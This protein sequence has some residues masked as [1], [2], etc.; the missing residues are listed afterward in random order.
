MTTAEQFRQG[1]PAAERWTYLNTAATSPTHEKVRAAMASFE[2]DRARRGEHGW[3]D[4]MDEVGGV[5]KVTSWFF[6][7][8]PEEVALMKNTSDG[9]ATVADGIQWKRGDEVV[10]T[11]QEFPSNILPWRQLKDRGVTLRIVESRNGLVREEDVERALSDRTR[12]LTFSS[13]FFT[14]G[15]ALD[16]KRL[17]AV[18]H[19]RGAEVLVDAIQGAGAVQT[20][21]RGWDVDYLACGGHKW[22]MAP[23]GVGT[24][25]VRRSLVESLKPTHV[26]WYGLADNEDYTPR[27]QD[28]A[29]TARR[30]EV[31]NLNLGGL[32]G[33][34][35]AL[36]TLT[37]VPDRQERVRDLSGRLVDTFRSAGLKPVTPAAEKERAGIV[38]VPVKD[39]GEAVAALRTLR[40]LVAARGP[41]V[42]FSPHFWNTQDEVLAAAD[43][44]I[45]HEKGGGSKDGGR[46]GRPQGRRGPDGGRQGS[47]GGPGQGRK[48]SGGGPGDQR[49]GS[50]GGQGQ[51][52]HGKR[53]S[54]R[55]GGKGKKGEGPGKPGGQGG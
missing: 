11:D 22:L 45:A 43:A 24:L 39:V 37:T 3:D 25:L 5:R 1:V 14:T 55:R 16:I 44:L 48:G 54:R 41:Y 49:K 20:S 19:D 17:T 18:A 35:A 40:I 32:A 52:K 4:W 21:F 31:G 36:G 51:K 30:F 47:G 8:E 38:S 13:V 28:L 26:G 10:T 29:R 34:R 42:R 53:R 27:N 9:I 15:Q 6:E 46:G 7:C 50:G 33:W 23:F 2:E 12:L